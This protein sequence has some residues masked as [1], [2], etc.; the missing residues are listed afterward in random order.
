M[1]LEKLRGAIKQSWGRETCYPKQVGKWTPGNPSLG[2]CAVTALVVQ[3]YFGGVLLYCK[4]NDHYWN[5]LPNQQ[6][7]DFTRDQFPNGTVIYIDEVR[8]RDYIFNTGTFIL[9]RYNLLRERV[10][11][12]LETE[13]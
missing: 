7:I 5:K 3:D 1:D 11:E 13:S 4:H 9:Q 6:E 10:R 8:T 12:K 2:Q